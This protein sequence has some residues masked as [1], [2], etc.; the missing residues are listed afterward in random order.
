MGKGPIAEPGERGE[1]SADLKYPWFKA[2]NFRNHGFSH[3]ILAIPVNVR[4][5]QAIDEKNEL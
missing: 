1:S 5:N 3:E 2:K 4:L